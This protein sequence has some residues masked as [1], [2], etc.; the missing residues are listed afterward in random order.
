[1]TGTATLTATRLVDHATATLEVTVTA[2]ELGV[3]SITLGAPVPR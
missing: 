2:S 3:F 1:M